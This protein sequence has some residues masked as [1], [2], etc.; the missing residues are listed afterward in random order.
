MSQKSVLVIGLDGGTLDVIRPWAE[1]GELPT[2]QRLLTE[3]VSGPLKSTIPAFSPPAWT[4]F[5]TGVN[6]GKHGTF[7]FV[8]RRPGGY[9]LQP[10]RN[11]LPSLGTMFA[12]A[13]RHGRRVAVV[14]VPLTYPPEPVNG[15]MVS[16]LGA[17]DDADYTYPPGLSDTLRAMGYRVNTDAR[18]EP[19][20]E[21]AFIRKVMETTNKQAEVALWLLAQE[22]W[23]FFTVVFRDLDGVFASLWSLMDETHP[24]HNPVR[25]AK[26]GDAILNYHK[27]LDARLA[28]FLDAIHDNTVVIVMS[29]H[30]SGPLYREVYL[31]VWLQREGFQRLKQGMGDINIG[32]RAL[33][34]YMGMTRENLTALLG[35][36]NVNRIKDRLPDRVKALIPRSSPETTDVVDWSRTQ[37]YSYGYIG[38]IYINLKGREPQGIVEPGAEYQR[39]VANII[40]RL[41]TLEDPETG[42]RVI[43]AV[44][45]KEELYHGPYA[46]LGPDLCLV[47]KDF[48]Y[49]THLGTEFTHGEVFGPPVNHESGTHRLNGMLM[50][51]GP[52]V[53][54]HG[55]VTS[56]E[57][58]DLAPTILHLLNVPVPEDMDGRVL[59]ELFD[60]SAGELSERVAREQVEAGDGP[61]LTAGEE[62]EL[63]ERLR[64]LGYLA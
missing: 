39:V 33:L 45:R 29:D 6:P 51:W 53:C 26:Y 52:G 28:D 13:S 18:Y 10:V 56:A 8:R 49:T 5:M 47:M 37:A 60:D 22:P 41:F 40:D 64:N 19:G 31:N 61:P 34:R 12:W 42:E 7:D 44:Y 43:D 20:L 3:G 23:D 63:L 30:G 4:S 62:A 48:S 50:A 58:I 21:D 9:D 55:C 59:T 46:H 54:R 2:F 32:L 38:Q 24:Q 27:L 57:I 1:A 25:A 17:P 11:H 14:N 16:G 15:I 35:W 36:S